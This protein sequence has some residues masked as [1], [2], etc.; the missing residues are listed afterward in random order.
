M[1]GPYEGDVVVDALLGTGFGGKTSGGGELKQEAAVVIERINAAGKRAIIVAVDVPSGL[2]CDT[3][4]P[5]SPTVYADMTITFI[6]EKTGFA[7]PLAQEHL[8]QVVVE[9]IGLPQAWVRQVLDL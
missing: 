6:A 2:D 3:G 5:A 9:D 1:D 4:K 8:G 7:A